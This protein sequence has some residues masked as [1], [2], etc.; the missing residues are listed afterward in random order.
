LNKYSPEG[1]Q[2][3]K[4][5]GQKIVDAV[6]AHAL[7]LAQEDGLGLIE[8]SHVINATKRVINK[9]TSNYEKLVLALTSIILVGLVFFQFSIVYSS[10][11]ISLWMLPVGCLIWVCAV[12]S[13]FR[14]Y[15]T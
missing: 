2:E 13:V 11:T 12:F 14:R 10:P 5:Q 15:L 8:A 6:A 1:A 4:K 9:T 7:L 3:I